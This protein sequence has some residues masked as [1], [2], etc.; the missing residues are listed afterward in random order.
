[1]AGVPDVLIWIEKETLTDG[2]EVFNVKFGDEVLQSVTEDDANNLA[3]GMAELI[4][5]H[6]NTSA[7]VMYA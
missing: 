2:S 1:M 7:G 5:N 6:T 4:N 3:E